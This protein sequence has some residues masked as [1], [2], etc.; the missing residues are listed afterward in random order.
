MNSNPASLL[1]WPGHIQPGIRNSLTNNSSSSSALQPQMSDPPSLTSTQSTESSQLE[2]TQSI[3]QYNPFPRRRKRSTRQNSKRSTK[4]IP[5]QRKLHHFISSTNCNIPSGQAKITPFL[6][7][8][9]LPT[10]QHALLPGA[11]D[12]ILSRQQPQS[13]KAPGSSNAIIPEANLKKSAHMRF[14]KIN[15]NRIIPATIHP[16][17]PTD[18]CWGHKLESIDSSTILRVVQQNPNGLKLQSSYEDFTLG[19]NICHSLGAGILSM[20]ETNVNWNQPYQ[21]QRVNAVVRKI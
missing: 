1:T 11:T 12:H 5:L 17:C 19:M 2:A 13:G 14:P 18:C 8:R 20:T 7:S 6:Q 15:M 16:S 3:L 21:V 9:S 10:S 4:G